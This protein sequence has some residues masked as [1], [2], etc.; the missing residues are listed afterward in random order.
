MS[1][2]SRHYA[3]IFSV[4]RAI[5]R[6]TVATYGQV[7]EMAGLPGHA[8]Q[9]GYALA[10]YDGDEAL[11]WQRVVNAQGRVSPR[12]DPES[13]EVQRDLLRAEGVVFDSTGRLDLERFRW[14]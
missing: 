4:V 3:R 13:E 10:A 7:A 8:R 9:V 12:A 1:E 11:P 14:G 2:R 6:G 5:P